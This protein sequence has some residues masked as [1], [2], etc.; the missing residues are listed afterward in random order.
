MILF[1]KT[2]IEE[3]F[4][5]GWIRVNTLDKNNNPRWHGRAI[6]QFGNDNITNPMSSTRNCSSQEPCRILNCPFTQYGSDAS[7]ICLTM[8]N[9]TTHSTYLDLD[10]LS[11]AANVTVKQSLSLTM[12]MATTQQT[13]YESINYIGMLYPTIDKPILYMPE[14]ARKKLPCSDMADTTST[15]P[16][17]MP[18]AMSMTT[19]MIMPMMKGQKCYN[20]IVVQYNDIIEFLV[21]NHDFDQHPMHLH[22][23]SFHVIEQ[24]LAQLNKTTGQFI[25]NNP[26]VACRDE[27]IDCTCVN[28]TTNT[29]LV[30]DTIQL[31]KGG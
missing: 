24:G 18:M 2:E 25:A 7:L 30:K 8:Q 6:L 15:T 9:M 16:M 10:L 29:R 31:P 27:H 21:I 17:P 12:V 1:H 20:N 28:C 19:S 13:G 26:N 23:F 14:I 4:S 5:L 3:S 22:G 11:D